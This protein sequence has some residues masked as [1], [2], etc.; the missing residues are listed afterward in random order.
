MPTF[1]NGLRRLAC[2]TRRKRTARQA[3]GLVLMRRGRVC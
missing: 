2:E 1:L 3:R